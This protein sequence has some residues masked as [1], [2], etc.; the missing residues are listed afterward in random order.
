[1]LRENFQRFAAR[2][3]TRTALAPCPSP[4]GKGTRLFEQIAE[5]L[6]E[7]R[8]DPV[9]GLT[10]GPRSHLQLGGNLGRIQAVNRGAQKAS[11]VRS[12]KSPRIT[13]IARRIRLLL[14]AFDSSQI[15][16]FG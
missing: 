9:L 15:D 8:Q 12:W 3:T 4:G 1:M 7:S 16:S 10:Y 5:L 2:C 13:F 6:A 11:H 14:L